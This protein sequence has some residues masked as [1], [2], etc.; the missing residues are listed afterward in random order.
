MLL[1]LLDELTVVSVLTELEGGGGR[2]AGGGGNEGIAPVGGGG[3]STDAG[4]GAAVVD[5]DGSAA[6]SF[7]GIIM[8]IGVLLSSATAGA[9]CSTRGF[10]LR[11]IVDVYAATVYRY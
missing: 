8:D 4:G 5:D 7:L 3:I 11:P 2:L 6:R 10:F 9:C 1:L